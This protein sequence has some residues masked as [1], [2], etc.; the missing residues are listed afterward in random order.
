MSNVQLLEKINEIIFMPLGMQDDTIPG[1]F[2]VSIKDSFPIKVTRPQM[3]LM[4]PSLI[5][6]NDREIL[7]ENLT[8]FKSSQSPIIKQV[9]HS[10]ITTNAIK[11]LDWEYF[12]NEILDTYY[13]YSTI[14]N[15][16]RQIRF[17]SLK[18]LYKIYIDSFT[19]LEE[20]KNISL[21]TPLGKNYDKLKSINITTEFVREDGS[22][23]GFNLA[24]VVSDT[25]NKNQVIF[26]FN[27][28]M[29][30]PERINNSN[31]SNWLDISNEIILDSIDNI[32]K[33]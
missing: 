6:P 22:I 7:V 9:G 12:R 28:I 8:Q 27:S 17:I 2:Y 31:I 21:T 33:K 32:F 1:M 20:Y 15:P 5:N 11:E 29:N 13:K 16:Q 14:F 26:D 18:Y 3:Q 10:L 19:E 23:S 4:V 24:S 30:I 25:P